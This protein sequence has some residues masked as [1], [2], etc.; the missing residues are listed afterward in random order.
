MLCFPF[1]AHAAQ[2]DTVA[3]IDMHGTKTYFGSA[4]DWGKTWD[5]TKFTDVTNQDVLYTQP[6]NLIIKSGTV[7]SVESDGKLTMEGGTADDIV[8]NNSASVT[9][10]TV[11]SIKAAGDITVSG[12]NVFQSITSESGN[13]TLSGNLTMGCSI[14]GS[15]VTFNS[16]KIQIA[17]SVKASNVIFT[18]GCT[19]TIGGTVTAT[20]KIQLNACTLSVRSL[21]GKSSAALIIN[22]Y[23]NS[24]PQ[25]V[26]MESIQLSTGNS[27]VTS[28]KIKTGALV[29]PKDSTLTA[30][31]P[32][33]VD[34]L[35]GPGMLC[36]NAG[37]LTVHWSVS[38]TPSIVFLSPTT[39][40]T[41]VLH[42]D[43]G[44]V[45]PS[46]VLLPIGTLDQ[47]YLGGTYVYR[48]K[49]NATEGL[50]LSSQS[51]TVN[52]KKSGTIQAAISPGIVRYAKGTKVVWKLYGDTK[53]FTMTPSS[54]G[55]TCG[56][57]ASGTEYHKALLVAYLIDQR[58]DQLTDYRADSCI[59]VADSATSGLKLDTTKVSIL[60]GDK[61]GVLA[62]GGDGTMP[63]A[64][65]SNASVA[66]LSEGK[67]VKD[68][69]GNPAWF[70]TITGG[71]AGTAEINI[72]G[73][74]VAV[75]VNSGILMDTMT[76]SMSPDAKYCVGLLTKGV[77][78]DNLRIYSTSDC[79]DVRFYRK[80]SDGKILYQ[81][82]GKRDGAADI[83]YEVIGG[84]S[85]R[86]H[87]T[88]KTGQKSYGS[89]ARLVA[90]HQ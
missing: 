54:D 39:N 56:I 46:Q 35:Q 18:S 16:G 87:V 9:G 36:V 66:A 75:T 77:S 28:Q 32:V 73:Q 12:G 2:A 86:T 59:L 38:D 4:T 10:G 80:G 81:I 37:A 20:D 5:S 84:Q 47:S 1:G 30:Y 6:G 61:Y 43:A 21:D 29:L 31:S 71:N 58:G 65:S 7:K 3:Y 13:I 62:V 55:L 19:T 67:A 79:A 27:I 69:S 49:N 45:L 57:S 52:S 78:E 63:I 82:I 11:K 14:T 83:V 26:N 64:S 23:T 44:N 34:C 24:L 8:S 25:I 60:T 76:Y 53:G 70:Y 51:M 68:N 90:L 40:G 88:V 42:A 33:E 48:V 85:I 74:K 17:N 72:G 41:S 89:S 50:A 22:G 15:N